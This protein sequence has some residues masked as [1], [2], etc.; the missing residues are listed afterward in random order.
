MRMEWVKCCQLKQFIVKSLGKWAI[1]SEKKID[2]NKV[3]DKL[4]LFVCH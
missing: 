1:L 4:D 3:D 2:L